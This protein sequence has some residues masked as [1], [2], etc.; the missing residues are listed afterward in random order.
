LL[1]PDITILLLQNQCVLSPVMSNEIS[2]IECQVVYKPFYNDRVIYA[3]SKDDKE[4][5]FS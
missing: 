4:L 5:H 1:K 3:P 2:Y